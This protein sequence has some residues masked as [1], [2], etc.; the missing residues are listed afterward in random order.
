MNMKLPHGFDRLTDKAY[1]KPLPSRKK[2]LE[3]LSKQNKL[4]HL[5][6]YEL[7]TLTQKFKCG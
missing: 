4:A 2:L 1:Q 6:S 7:L 5:G 3:F